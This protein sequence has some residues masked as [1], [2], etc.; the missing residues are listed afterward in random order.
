[1]ATAAGGCFSRGTGQML[2]IVICDGSPGSAVDELAGCLLE[3]GENRV[4]HGTDSCMLEIAHV[5]RLE[6]W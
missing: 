1:M 4:M 5:T 3:L 6:H 2:G